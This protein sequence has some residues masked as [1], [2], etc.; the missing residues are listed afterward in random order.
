MRCQ[1]ALTPPV[2]N[3]EIKE[4][5]RRLASS[6]VDGNQIQTIEEMVLGL[7]E[8]DDIRKLTRL[9]AQPMKAR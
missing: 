6:V 1:R 5:W 8:L 3:E 7:G 4:K 2:T 9:L